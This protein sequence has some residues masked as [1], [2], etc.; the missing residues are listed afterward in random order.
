[1]PEVTDTTEKVETVAPVVNGTDTPDGAATA[2]PE[3]TAGTQTP[4][5]VEE[6]RKE[7]DQARMRANQ[8]E[9]EIK[10]AKEAADA[11]EAARLKEAGK[12][13]ELAEKLQREKEEREAAEAKKLADQQAADEE[14]ARTKRADDLR[15]SVLDKFPKNVQE[16]ANKLDLWWGNATTEADAQAQLESKLQALQTTLPVVEDPEPEIH[17]NNGLG[18][19]E[20]TEIDKLKSLSAAEMRKIL[21]VAPGR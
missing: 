11:A 20:L 10:A 18:E 8:L 16:M 12:Y 13:E 3:V 4:K 9:N 7:R 19:P 17:G 6:A 2:T 21:P 15:Q 1:M 14:A 5:E